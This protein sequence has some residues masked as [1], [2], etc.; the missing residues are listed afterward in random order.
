MGTDGSRREATLPRKVLEDSVARRSC[1]V[2][3]SPQTQV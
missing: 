2:S 1:S 3:V